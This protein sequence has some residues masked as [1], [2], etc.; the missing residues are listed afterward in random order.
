MSELRERGGWGHNAAT[1]TG[2]CGGAEGGGAEGVGGA[3]RSGAAVIRNL[4]SVSRQVAGVAIGLAGAQ[5]GTAEGKAEGRPGSALRKAPINCGAVQRYREK[6][7]LGY[8]RRRFSVL[9]KEQTQ[10]QREAAVLAEPLFF[11][12]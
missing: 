4:P 2:W 5:H 6:E 8:S 12:W 1:M 7:E 11:V 9:R 10:H 3:G